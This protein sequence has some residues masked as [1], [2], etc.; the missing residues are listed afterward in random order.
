ME[1]LR[2]LPASRVRA[3]SLGIESITVRTTDGQA[4]GTLVGLLVEPGSQRIRSLI[5][6]SAEGQREV[7]MVPVQ[8]DSES[9]SLRIMS[10]DMCAH[11]FCEGSVPTISDEDLWV[12]L[13]RSAA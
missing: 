1:T 4:I 6:E 10:P 13:F 9:A 5:V 3:G 12:P 7:E 2:Y 11:D 8:F